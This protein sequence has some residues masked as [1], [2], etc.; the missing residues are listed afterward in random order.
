MISHIGTV[1]DAGSAAEL[2]RA[3]IVAA[4]IL[5]LIFYTEKET[6]EQNIALRDIKRCVRRLYT[7]VMEDIDGALCSIFSDDTI[8]DYTIKH[9]LNVS[10]LS[11][12]TAYGLGCDKKTITDIGTSALLHDVGKRF[13]ARDIIY[14]KSFLSKEEM[15]VVR[16]HTLLGASHIRSIYPDI[17]DDLTYGIL[18]HHERL[19]GRGYP[20]RL[21]EN[22]PY[23]ARIIAV[24]DVFEAYMAKRPYHE[25]RS[26]SEGIEF[27]LHQEGMDKD[28][29]KSLVKLLYI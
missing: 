20:Y 18:Y 22:I 28:I 21:G 11:M 1:Y 12:L 27:I 17:P 14:K 3:E 15:K 26:L 13:V 9:S 4:A 19:N 16:K 5:E 23:I 25:K 10:I 6:V 7:A 2:K 24:S 8:G 29:V